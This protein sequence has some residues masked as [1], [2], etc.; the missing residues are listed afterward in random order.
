MLCKRTFSGYILL[1]CLT[2]LGAAAA[3]AHPRMLE[4]KVNISV[5]VVLEKLPLI[6]QEKMKDFQEKVH[7]YLNEYEWIEEQDFPPFNMHIQ[8]FLEDQPSNI[9][10]RYRC[11]VVVSGP[12]VQ[13]VDER[14]LFAFQEDQELQHDGQH[15]SL[16][17]LLDFYM[18]LV[19]AGEFDKLGYLQGDP[20]ITKARNAVKLGLF[21]RFV[22][23]WD[24]R[25]DL[26]KLI[27]G[28]NY[29]LFREMKDYYFYGLAVYEEDKKA[30]RENVAKAVTMLRDVLATD[31][32][33]QAAKDFISAHF[34][35]ICEMFKGTDNIK[36]IK[37]L[38]QLDPEHEEYYA[39]F[40]N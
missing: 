30:A 34:R 24:R 33:L 26:M 14:A 23:G 4:G 27:D 5:D 15:D 25:D 11:S 36:P 2:F 29:K 10:D 12:D 1:A 9:E 28:E 20:Y 19:I 40:L 39:E 18:Y 8:L 6:K 32:D 38:S 37:T 21:D 17:L 22:R 31:Y 3:N 13:Y 16:K 7:K 35:T